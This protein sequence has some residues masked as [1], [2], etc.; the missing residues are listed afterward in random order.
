MVGCLLGSTHSQGKAGGCSG[1]A[2]NTQTAS[3]ELFL[4]RAA[5]LPEQ[6]WRETLDKHSAHPT[7]AALEKPSSHTHIY[8]KSLH[9]SINSSPT[10]AAGN[11]SPVWGELWEVELT[12]TPAPS[13]P[14]CLPPVRLSSTQQLCRTL[15]EPL[16]Q[17]EASPAHLCL[18]SHGAEL[19]VLLIQTGS[20]SFAAE[21]LGLGERMEWVR[22]LWEQVG[23]VDAKKGRTH[24][25]N[26]NI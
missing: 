11:T 6:H 14:H 8:R 18:P 1:P 16:P 13:P 22:R 9:Q 19:T 21:I 15:E 23:G 26:L 7:A 24:Q 5:G 3:G 25:K 2:G 12:P 10:N 4:C 20:Q 17:P